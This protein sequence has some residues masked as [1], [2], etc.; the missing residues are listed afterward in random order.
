MTHLTPFTALSAFLESQAALVQHH[1]SDKLIEGASKQ[2]LTKREQKT[3]KEMKARLAKFEAKTDDKPPQ[4]KRRSQPI[5]NRFWRKGWESVQSVTSS[6]TTYLREVK[7]KT[8][9][10]L[11]PSLPD[12]PSIWLLTWIGD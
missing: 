8:K 1:M 5:P 10:L 7:L 9:V 6:I 11:A 4:V 3:V 12:V 2:S